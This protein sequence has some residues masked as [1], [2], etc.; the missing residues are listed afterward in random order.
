LLFGLGFDT[1]TEVGLL[2]LAGGAA[3]SSL[4]WYAILTLPALFA[5]GMTL[6]D[7]VD[8]SFMNFA[9]GWAFSRPVRKVYYNIT[10]TGLSVAVALFIGTIELLSILADKR[11]ITAG[12][13]RLDRRI[14]SQP[15]RVRHRRVVRGHLGRRTGG[16]AAW[17]HRG[18]VARRPPRRGEV[19][20]VRRSRAPRC[21]AS[22][23]PHSRRSVARRMLCVPRDVRGAPPAPPYRPR[24]QASGRR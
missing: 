9:Y 16:M 17:P 12:P 20:R 18:K 8:G 3:A 6:L 14:G 7:S 23:T 22:R 21:W 10:V 5:A 2:V 19:R 4:P 15:G 24:C 11:S 1:A 13:G